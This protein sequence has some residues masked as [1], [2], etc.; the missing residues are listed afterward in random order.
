VHNWG[1]IED[2][3]S[4]QSK[5]DRSI[6]SGMI[7]GVGLPWNDTHASIVGQER[8][9]FGN[10]TGNATYDD[11]S[12]SDP[13]STDGTLSSGGRYGNVPQ[14]A[15][16][17]LQFLGSFMIIANTIAVI[18]LTILARRHRIR[19]E[20]L[21]REETTTDAEGLR[22]EEGVTS[23]LMESKQFALEKSQALRIA[24]QRRRQQ[25]QQKQSSGTSNPPPIRPAASLSPNSSRHRTNNKET[26]LTEKRS[27]K[28]YGSPTY[29]DR[30]LPSNSA[31]D[32]DV[33]AVDYFSHPLPSNHN[34]AQL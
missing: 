34:S 3:L 11:D 10:V 1:Q 13:T 15:A 31:D 6:L 8:E 18:L 25:Q 20:K 29:D 19:K 5:L 28:S 9:T 16:K 32:E 7:D 33:D 22:T 4:I 2:E 26:N 24:E 17:A 27:Y 23:M 30:L 12:Y 21:R 14:R